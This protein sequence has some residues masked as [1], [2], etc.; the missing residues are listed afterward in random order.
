M[1]TCVYTYLSIYTY[2][3]HADPLRSKFLVRVEEHLVG[4][5]IVALHLFGVRGSG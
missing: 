1:H 5:A 2:L 3:R 4:H